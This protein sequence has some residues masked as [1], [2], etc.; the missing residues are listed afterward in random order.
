M[1]IQI[2]A[3]MFIIL[4]LSACSK[5]DTPVTKVV[6]FASTTYET[7]GMYDSLGKPD[8]LLTKDS[9]SAALLSF[10]NNILPNGKDLRI[11][12]PELFESAAIAD[13]PIKQPSDVFITFV[14]QSAG[15]TNAIAFYTYPT[16]QPP[17]TAKDIKMIT[18]VFP[19]AGNYTALQPGDKVKIGRFNAGTSVGFV[20]LQAAWNT[21]TNTLD[22]KVVHFCSN[23]ALNPEVDPNLKRHAVL[24]NYAPQNKVLIGFEDTDRTR[25]ECDND[26]NDEVIYCTVTP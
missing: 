10:I 24:I 17:A 12:H 18:Y 4:M 21:T 14:S 8:Y 23:D 25:P 15:L 16:N 2:Y 7:L 20:L 5:H 9:I 3:G 22:N 11:L 19:N 26:F 13:I 6:K 1:K